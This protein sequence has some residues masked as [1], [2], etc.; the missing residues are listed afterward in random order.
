MTRAVIYARYSSDHQREASIEDQVRLCRALAEREG[1]TVVHTY[2]DR[3]I[4]GTSLLRPGYQAVM[5]HARTGEVD[6]ILAESLDRLSR[7]QEETAALFKRLQFFGVLL[8]TAAEGVITE[9]HV[10]LKGT[11]NALYLKDLAQKTHRG[12]EGRVRNGKSGGGIS[13]GYQVVQHRDPS[14]E[15]IRGDRVIDKHQADVVRRIFRDYAAGHA[16]RAIAQA[17]NREGEPGPGGQG[18]SPSTIHG[19]WRRGTGILNNE[20]YIGRLV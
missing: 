8:I 12:L 4:S 15:P 9:L 11:M 10:G 1:Y 3:A 5:E 7:D 16:T 14:G 13:Y 6:V 20:L 18:W 2:G 17:L 19:N